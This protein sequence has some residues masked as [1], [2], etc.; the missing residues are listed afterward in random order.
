LVAAKAEK[1]RNDGCGGN[2]DEN[3]VVETNTVEGIQE[4]EP[5][6]NFM[7]L[8][9]GLKDIMDGKWPS[10]TS[11]MVRDSQDGAKVVG[12]MT[13]CVEQDTKLVRTKQERR[14][15]NIRQLRNNRCNQ[16]SEFECQY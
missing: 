4:S 11:K 5:T 13:P 9:H 10:L 6:L 8:D 15:T 7:G 12:W 14:M 3:D 2:F 1:L 16:A